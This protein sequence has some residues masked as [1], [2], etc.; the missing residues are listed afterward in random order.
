MTSRRI[1]STLIGLR[2]RSKG[3]SNLYVDPGVIGRVRMKYMKE[4][5]SRGVLVGLSLICP[6]ADFHSFLS[7]NRSTASS[8]WLSGFCSCLEKR[9]DEPRRGSNHDELRLT[10]LRNAM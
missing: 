8:L 3:R 1:T 4:S 6:P 9:S 7:G 5:S 2:A 10:A